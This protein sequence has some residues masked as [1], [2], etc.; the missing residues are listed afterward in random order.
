MNA[1]TVDFFANCPNNG[2]RIKYRLRIES[3]M[4]IR[5]EEIMAEVDRIDDQFHEEI[6]TQLQN[7]LGGMH[8]L[9]ADHH[10]VTIETTRGSA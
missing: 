3:T 9:I 1:Y 7:A 6:A 4:T 8:T 5:V 2:I 10:G